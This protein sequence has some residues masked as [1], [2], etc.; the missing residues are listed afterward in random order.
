MTQTEIIETSKS[1]EEKRFHILH[2]NQ[3]AGSIIYRKQS[4]EALAI[5]GNI[6]YE[7]LP[8]FRGNNLAYKACILLKEILKK[9][10]G[11][12]TITAKTDNLPSIKTIRK[13]K[14]KEIGEITLP[15]GEVR[16]RFLWI[17]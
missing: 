10:R 11:S 13:L 4:G 15:T 5:N 9:E 12:I 1:K 17:F 7:I 8:N 2:S 3:H 16:K 6:E 14:A